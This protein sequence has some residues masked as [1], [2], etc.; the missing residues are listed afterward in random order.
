[1]IKKAEI[2]NRNGFMAYGTVLNWEDAKLSS[3]SENHEY[4]DAVSEFN[5]EGP[6][7]CSFLKIKK[8]IT[9]PI[10]EMECH[11]KTEELLLAAENDI[12]VIVAKPDHTKQA[13]DETTVKCFYLKQGTGIILKPGMWHALPCTVALTS[14]MTFIVFKKHTSYSEDQNTATDIFFSKLKEPFHVE[15]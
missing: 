15:L 6:L 7:V 4:W 3:E 5:T 9:D 13:P 10:E 11:Y 14:S 1:M 2:I 8:P 12:V